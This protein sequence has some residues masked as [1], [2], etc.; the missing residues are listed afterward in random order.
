MNQDWEEKKLKGLFHE[1][2]REDERLAPSFARDWEAALSRI[3][4]A[5]HPPRVFRVAAATVMLIV[6]GS[7][8]F[9][10]FRQPAR[11]P[12]P[13]GAPA[14]EAPVSVASST[15]QSPPPP[16]VPLFKAPGKVL[17]RAVRRQ[18]SARPRQSAVFISQWRSPTDFLL[19]SP[20]E[21][22]LKT[23][24]RPGESVREIKASMPDQ[25]N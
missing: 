18:S 12:A 13:T 20:G 9:I 15:H 17:P 6:L 11:Q 19:K 10:L 3:G 23:V 14:E 7:S 1:L 4:K 21:Q 8:V 22:L 24:P 25:N 2:R 16:L 5:R